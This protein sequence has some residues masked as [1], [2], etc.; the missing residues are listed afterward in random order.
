[1]DHKTY[2]PSS[3]TCEDLRDGG[4]GGSDSVVLSGAAYAARNS[5]EYAPTGQT[6]AG[7]PVYAFTD[8]YGLTWSLYRRSYGRW[9]VDFNGVDDTWAGTVSY[10]NVV[11]ENTAV[12]DDAVTWNRPTTDVVAARSVSPSP[13]SS[14]PPSPP[15]ERAAATAMYI[16]GDVPYAWL[17]AGMYVLA[18]RTYNNEPVYEK[19][20]SGG[21]TWTLYKRAYGRWVLDFD[22]IDETWSGTVA[23][24]SVEHGAGGLESVT[25]NRDGMTVSSSPPT[26][27]SH[28]IPPAA[29]RETGNAVAATDAPPDDELAPP[30]SDGDGG[31]N[32]DDDGVAVLREVA[33]IKVRVEVVHETNSRAFTSL[34]IGVAAAAVGVLIVAI[35]LIVYA[36]HHRRPHRAKTSANDTVALEVVHAAVAPPSVNDIEA[37]TRETSAAERQR[38]G[39]EVVAEISGAERERATSFETEKKEHAVRL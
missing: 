34:T 17:T 27:S 38:K 11:D 5:G 2:V 25:W 6:H 19:A 1:M 21:Y 20:D 29:H 14:P 18:A 22:E 36:C 15:P 39:A 31:V 26:A 7:Q 3:G 8:R 33:E 32:G 24:S 16:D 30:T 23:Y 10:S 35:A 4:G 12:Y 28:H 13:P 9:V 37:A